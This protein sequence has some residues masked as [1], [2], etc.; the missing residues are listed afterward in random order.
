MRNAFLRSVHR[1]FGSNSSKAM[2][3][4]EVYFYGHKNRQTGY[5]S[6]FYPCRFQ[7]DQGTAYNCSEQYF[8]KK[9][10]ELFDQ[11]NQ[12]L[13]G[14]ILAAEDPAV[15][16]KYGRQVQNYHDGVWSAERYGIMRQGLFYKFNQNQDLAELLLATGDKVCVL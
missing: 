16:K 15:I 1:N 2:N 12:L 10:Q 14:K 5:L 7:D 9:K 13:A 4:N 3:P 8:M 6:N 11:E